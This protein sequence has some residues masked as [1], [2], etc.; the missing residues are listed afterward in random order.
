MEVIMYELL[1]LNKDQ[2]PYNLNQEETKRLISWLEDV[3][4]N[5]PEELEH[6]VNI[7]K[8]IID[9]IEATETEEKVEH[10]KNIEANCLGSFCESE[11]YDSDIFD[12]FMTQ[13]EDKY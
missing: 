9:F 11:V 6:A 2:L 3:K 13:L 8:E 5:T 7:A 10:L 4:R 12:R 1:H